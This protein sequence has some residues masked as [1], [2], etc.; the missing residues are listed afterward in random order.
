VGLALFVGPI[1]LRRVLSPVIGSESG[2]R[3]LSEVPVLV[4]IPRII[5]ERGAALARRRLVRNVSLSL[6]SSATLTAVIAFFGT[7]G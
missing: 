4:S 2:L 7:T 6:L 3:A 5:T 1:P